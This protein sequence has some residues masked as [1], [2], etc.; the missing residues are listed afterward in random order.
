[1]ETR[2][3]NNVFSEA[4]YEDLVAEWRNPKNL[5]MSCGKELTE[6]QASYCNEECAKEDGYLFNNGEYPVGGIR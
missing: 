6:P 2:N 3:G 4:G 1:M 5:C